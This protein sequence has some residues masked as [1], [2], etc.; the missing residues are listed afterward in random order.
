MTA[1]ERF[2]TRGNHESILK[3]AFTSQVLQEEGQA[4]LD[5]Q[6]NVI[7]RFNLVDS[8]NLL[9]QR[10]ASAQG[11]TLH[12]AFPVYL[13]LLDIK[14]NKKK[15]FPL[16]NSIVMGHFNEIARK[17]RFGFTEEVRQQLSMELN[18]EISA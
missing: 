16:H 9:S 4:I 8:R 10:F 18:I 11:N 5:D 14:G 1:R 7:N 17:L 12:M 2:D 6:T 3:S 15:A 13:R